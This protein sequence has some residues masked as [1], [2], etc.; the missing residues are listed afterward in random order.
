MS[1]DKNRILC[2]LKFFALEPNRSQDEVAHLQALYNEFG[3]YPEPTQSTRD[4]A[5][6][7]RT[8]MDANGRTSARISCH[9]WWT[10]GY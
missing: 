5:Y 7:S 2:R 3:R 1:K 9:R 4:K 8:G 6:L 10:S